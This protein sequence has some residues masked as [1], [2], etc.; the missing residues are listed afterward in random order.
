MFDDNFTKFIFAFK[1]D[2]LLRL[3]TICPDLEKF[4][5]YKN[6]LVNIAD[7]HDLGK[8]T[9]NL[10]TPISNLVDLINSGKTKI[11]KFT[12]MR[13][14]MFYKF[15]WQDDYKRSKCKGLFEYKVNSSLTIDS[16]LDS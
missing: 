3:P 6:K 13:D 5:Y 1:S 9:S 8:P 14:T 10:G 15:E 2:P 12:L 16:M 11:K 7:S 4:C